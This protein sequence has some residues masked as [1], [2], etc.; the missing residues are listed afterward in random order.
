[1]NIA[2]SLIKSFKVDTADSNESLRN[3]VHKVEKH[4]LLESALQ[5]GKRAGI[6]NDMTCKELDEAS[7]QEDGYVVMVAEGKTFRVAGAS[8]VFCSAKEYRRLKT[9]VSDLRPLLKPSTDQVFCR[10]SGEHASVGETG[11]FLKEAW[12]DFGSIIS[13]DVGDVTFT[14]IRKTIV[15]KSRE[16]GVAQDVQEEMARHMDHSKDTAN[17]YYDVST[18]ARLTASFRRTLTAFYDPVE[19]DEESSTCSES[20]D[21]FPPSGKLADMDRTE[22]S[23]NKIS[24]APRRDTSAGGTK[25]TFGKL[26]VFTE[27]DKLRLLRCCAYLIEKNRRRKDGE[28]GVTRVEILA[29]IRSAGPN[30]SDLLT[31]YTL[32]QICNRVRCELRKKPK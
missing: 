11:E 26:D 6:F 27:N 32:A 24:P 19:S 2:E 14:L 31:N 23:V 20:E 9:F 1:M 13:K 29:C 12:V 10:R 21:A 18:G 30:F 28:K 7:E 25:S 17:K 5:N 22:P 3:R 15:S 8:G 16:E 4:L